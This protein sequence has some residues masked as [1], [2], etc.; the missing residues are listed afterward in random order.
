M[1]INERKYSNDILELIE[2]KGSLHRD[3]LY[4]SLIIK[5]N[6]AKKNQKKFKNNVY[7]NYLS[8]LISNKLI[9]KT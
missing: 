2:K 5:Y 1:D 9:A 6:I 3:D 8:K 4:K 7:S